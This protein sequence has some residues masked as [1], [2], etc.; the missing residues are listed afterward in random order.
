MIATSGFLTALECTKFI[1]GRGSP[2]TPLGKLTA[3]PRPS[4]W[5]TGALLLRA[6][7]G[8]GRGGDGR[9]GGEGREGEVN[10]GPM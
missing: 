1:F 5:F 8:K 9:E 10:A 3:L 2:R 7:G 6:K 4:S